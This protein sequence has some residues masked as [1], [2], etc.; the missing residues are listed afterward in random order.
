MDVM[1]YHMSVFGDFESTWRQAE[2]SYRQIMRKSDPVNF[3][4]VLRE[5]R[6][7]LLSY[8]YFYLQPNTQVL[9][10]YQQVMPSVEFNHTW[11]N[12][13]VV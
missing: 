11:F 8:Y 9:I 12:R 13:C 3:I 5:P 4:T 10:Y 1:H 6:S 2:M 7:H